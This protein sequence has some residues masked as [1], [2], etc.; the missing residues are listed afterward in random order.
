MIDAFITNVICWSAYITVFL[1]WCALTG[2][3]FGHGASVRRIAKL[4]SRYVLFWFWLLF[5]AGIVTHFMK[6]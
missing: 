2:L 4:V 5:S 6:W 1:G 3:I